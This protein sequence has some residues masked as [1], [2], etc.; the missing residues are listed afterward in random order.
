MKTKYLYILLL[1]PLF[2]FADLDIEK[3]NDALSSIKSNKE[4]SYF[5]NDKKFLT[6]LNI[7][8]SNSIKKADIILFP[9]GEN[10]KKIVIVNSYS[11]LKKDKESI[12]AIYVKKGRTQIM[13]VDERLKKNG[14]KI[15]NKKY[16]IN[17]CHL[18]PICFLKLTK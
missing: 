8:K 11:K 10:A 7:P 18:N 5:S 16:Q 3:V 4:L 15:I 17:E 1:A 6:K 12:G 9:E 14:L 2:S 13:F